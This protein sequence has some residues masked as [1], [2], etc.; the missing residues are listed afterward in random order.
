MTTPAD[1]LAALRDGAAYRPA[2]ADRPVTRRLDSG[3]TIEV[4]GPRILAETFALPTL[5][6]ARDVYRSGSALLFRDHG[7]EGEPTPVNMVHLAQQLRE[8]LA[9]LPDRPD[10]G[11]PYRDLKLFMT[12]GDTGSVSAYLADALKATRQAAPVWRPPAAPR[13]PAMTPAQRKAKQRERENAAEEAAARWWISEVLIPTLEDPAPIGPQPGEKI[14]AADLYQFA[15][16]SFQCWREDEETDHETPGPRIFY[17]VA[18]E[19]L[20]PSWRGTGGVK[21]YRLPNP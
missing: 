21:T 10:A 18:D 3:V 2:R 5:K 15:A 8:D 12:E 19:L 11:R 16:H 17:R 6:L 20:A 4:P 7:A 13:P 1:G 14:A 9:S